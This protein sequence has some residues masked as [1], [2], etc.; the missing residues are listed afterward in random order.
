LRKYPENV[1]A[2]AFVPDLVMALI[3][4]PVERPCAA[5]NRFVRISNSPMASRL[6]SG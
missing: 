4:M 1:P 2:N 6:Y 3:W 5:S